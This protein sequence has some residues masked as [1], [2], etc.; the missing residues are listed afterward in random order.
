VIGWIRCIAS[1][2][3][4]QTELMIKNTSYRFLSSRRWATTLAA[5]HF[6]PL[7]CVTTFSITDFWS[8]YHFGSHS[9]ALQYSEKLLLSTMKAP[10]PH[11]VSMMLPNRQVALPCFTCILNFTNILSSLAPV[12]CIGTLKYHLILSSLTVASRLQS[13]AFHIY[14]ELHVVRTRH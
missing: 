4:V 2:Y 8:Q 13:R 3:G 9:I 14:L 6:Q 11:V 12:A 10:R 1:V 5:T 7:M